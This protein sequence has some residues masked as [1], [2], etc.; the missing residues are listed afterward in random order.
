MYRLV[1]DL[2]LD[3][4]KTGHSKDG[5]GRRPLIDPDSEVFPSAGYFN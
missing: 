2:H 4:S 3:E 1:I 5:K